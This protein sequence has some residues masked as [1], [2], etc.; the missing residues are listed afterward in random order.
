VPAEDATDERRHLGLVALE[1]ARGGGD[2]L[3]VVA[4]LERDDGLH[5]EGK[6]LLGEAVLDHLR[7]LHRQRQPGGAGE[8]RDHEHPVPGDDLELQRVVPVLLAAAD[9]ER[10]V[11]RRDPVPEH[12]YVLSVVMVE[13]CASQGS[14]S[15]WRAPREWM[16]STVAPT[17]SGRAQ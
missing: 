5:T 15:I 1:P 12:V 10:L 6:S 11:R 17:G 8:D 14:T 2:R 13:E 7:L 3:V 9:Q 4:D 16:T